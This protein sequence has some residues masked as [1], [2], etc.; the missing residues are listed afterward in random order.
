MRSLGMDFLKLLP[1]ESVELL[2]LG[3]DVFHQF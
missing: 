1:V 3:I 2:A